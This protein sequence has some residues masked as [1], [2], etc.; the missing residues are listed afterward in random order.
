MLCEIR[1]PVKWRSA[2]RAYIGARHQSYRS[3]SRLKPYRKHFKSMS[4]AGDRGGR[5]QAWACHSGPL[6]HCVIIVKH[7]M[8][9]LHNL[10]NSTLRQWGIVALAVGPL[11]VIS[12]DLGA[13]R[14]GASKHSP[15]YGKALQQ[16]H[17]DRA[18]LAEPVSHYQEPISFAGGEATIAR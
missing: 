7:A 6:P 5:N 8:I 13:M 17:L 18:K 11:C 4:C 10:E 2:R 12:G 9:K 16:A 1:R 14:R 3:A 15:P